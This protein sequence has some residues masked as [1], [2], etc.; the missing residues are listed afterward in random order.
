MKN[1][2]IMNLPHIIVFV[3]TL[4]VFVIVSFLSVNSFALNVF[5]L[6]LLL[7]IAVLDWLDGYIARKLGVSSKIGGLID[8]LGDRITENTFLIFFAFKQLIP[9]FVPVIFVARSFI[10]DFVRYQAYQNNIGT[11]SVNKS[12]LGYIFVASKTSRAVYLA[13]KVIIFVLGGVI[14]TIGRYINDSN[15]A[16]L[17][18]LSLNLKV[19]LYFGAVFLVVFSLIRFFFLLFDAR[20]IL[21]EAFMFKE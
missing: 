20:F 19:L 2:F 6:F 7:F 1:R 21:G 3:R 15:Q 12:K 13:L 4:L 8:T 5:S 14:L 10:S 16:N 18:V 9:L 17:A 11:F